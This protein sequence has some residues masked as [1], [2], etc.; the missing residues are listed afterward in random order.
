MF[1]YI[2]PVISLLSEDEQALYK[3]VYC[4]MCHA[5]GKIAGQS[6]R[7]ALSY[8]FVFLALMRM[9]IDHESPVSTLRRCPIHPFRG[10]PAVQDSITLDYCA[11]LSV[12]LGYES[13][14]DKLHDEK[15]IAHV[16]AR[17]AKLPARRFLKKAE[18]RISLPREEVSKH[19]K[20]L[21]QIE[22]DGCESAEIPAEIFGELLADVSVYGIDD[23]IARFALSKIMFRLGKWIYLVDAADDFQE[24]K[25]RNRFNPF[26]PH[27]PDPY[28]LQ[29]SL[30]WELSYCDEMLRKIP[31]MD[32]KIRHII[33]NI[34]FLGTAAITDQVL[35]QN[36]NRKETE[37]E[38]SL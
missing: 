26:L 23:D 37:N 16:K 20:A 27:G 25:K 21:A 1:G 14:E 6:A 36:G 7:F 2:K 35:F 34:L 8:D 31:N 11:A 30:E 18:K 22:K 13:I 24:D 19:L 5:L 10:C 29:N 17:M 12:L 3:S 28:R 38:R 33:R 32:P 9:A 4:G 15:G